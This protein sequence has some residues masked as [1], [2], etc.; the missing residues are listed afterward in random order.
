MGQLKKRGGWDRGLR[1]E[2]SGRGMVGNA[3]AVL[4]HG[5]AD[6]Y[7]RRIEAS[8]GDSVRGRVLDAASV[9]E[10]LPPVVT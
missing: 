9:K 5:A 7:G 6:G 8:L 2:A 4:L 1:L 3:G 10:C